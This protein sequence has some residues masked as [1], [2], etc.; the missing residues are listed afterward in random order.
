M[1]NFSLRVNAFD[2]DFNVVNT[3]HK[4]IHIDEKIWDTR[5]PISVRLDE[6]QN[7]WYKE[8]LGNKYRF[9]NDDIYQAFIEQSDEWVHGEYGLLEDLR[10][11][12]LWPSIQK[13]LESV[14]EVEPSSI[15]TARQASEK[16]IQKSLYVRLSETLTDDQKKYMQEIAEYKYTRAK[17]W[18]DI[19]KQYTNRINCYA[20]YNKDLSEKLGFTVGWSGDTHE[21]KSIAILHDIHRF[22]NNEIW[23]KKELWENMQLPKE[24]WFS[25]D[26]YINIANIAQRIMTEKSIWWLRDWKFTLFHTDIQFPT[27]IS[28]KNS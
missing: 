6:F 22:N 8:N 28:I 1:E 25:D 10:Q 3:R 5:H 7:D 18:D 14:Y 20:M 19:L 16:A 11:N 21:R 9:R 2:L 12:D 26:E 17:K 4:I 13:L 23:I 15:I 27:K 24:Y